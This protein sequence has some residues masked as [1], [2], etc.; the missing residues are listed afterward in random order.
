MLY[1]FISYI[2]VVPSWQGIIFQHAI[3]NMNLFKRAMPL[4]AGM[5]ILSSCSDVNKTTANL[6][7]MESVRRY[8]KLD[9]NWY[10]KNLNA[11]SQSETVSRW[12]RATV[13]GTIHTDLLNNNLIEHPYRSTNED[14]LQWIGLEDWVY[15]SKFLLDTALI[16]EENLEIVFEGLDTY[17]SVYLNDSLIITADNMFRDWRADV[18]QLINKGENVLR[19]EFLSAYSQGLEVAKKYPFRLAAHNDRSEAKTS[20]HTR[21]AP[22]HYGWDWGPRFVTCGIFRPVVIEGWSSAKISNVHYIEKSQSKDIATFDANITIIASKADRVNLT[23]SDDKGVNYFGKVVEVK[24]GENIIN[25]PFEIKNPKLWWPNGTGKANLY[26]MN[27]LVSNLD[28]SI[29]YDEQETEIGVRTIKVI[30]EKD[31]DGI[32]EGFYV[33]VNGEPVFCKGANYIPQ[34]LFLPNIDEDKYEEFI[35]MCVESNYNMIRVWGGGVYQDDKFYELCDENGIMVWQDFMFACSLYPWDEEFFE[36]VEQEAIYNVRRLRNHPSVALWCGNNEIT[37]MW[38]HWGVQ[39]EYGWNEQQSQQV[40]DGMRALFYD[41]LPRVLQR[42]D[43]TRYYHPSSPLYGWAAPE[44]AHSGDV[45]YWGVFHGEQPFSVYKDR[46]GRFSNEYGFQSLACYDTYR[47]YFE[48]DELELY[49]KAMVV[50]QKNAKGYRVI[51]E[52]MERDLPILK[53]NFREYVYLSQILQAEGI[54]IAME[55]HRQ[56][57]PWTMG[58]VYWQVNDCWPVTS[59]SSMDSEMRWKALQYYARE[60]FKPTIL[61]F[62]AIDSSKMVKLWGMTDKLVG[63]RGDVTLSLLDFNGKELWREK[64]DINIPRN[65]NQEVFCRSVD[66]LLKGANAQQVAL[67]AKGEIEGKEVRKIHYFVPFKDLELPKADFEVVYTADDSDEVKV[68]ITAKT[69]LKNVLFEAEDIQENP[70][71]A[72]FDMLPGETK[73]VELSFK[74][75]RNR[76]EQRG[77]FVTTLNSMVGRESAKPITTNVE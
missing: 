66:E 1:I 10:F 12:T 41:L 77:I 51:E 33:E 14:K 45:H 18:K 50:H 73:E 19:V 55:G 35:E 34:D 61:S 8:H 20:V 53:D 52:Y 7:E 67:V 68:K 44:S 39:Y 74:D 31:A 13:P 16:A 70:S 22:Y 40:Y 65:G 24:E 46:P 63:Q 6:L 36:N 21:K 23:L 25:V 64:L 47:E 28:N 54:K 9:D 49:S 4:L 3:K 30:R 2:F 37:E 38:I 32:G 42:E 71:D 69:L 56:K 72:Y 60:S 57:R 17:A 27:L 15:E 58:S 59:W 48:T 29:K 75:K 11:L 43:T 26:E 76:V 5:A 62:E